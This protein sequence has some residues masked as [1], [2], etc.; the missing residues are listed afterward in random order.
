MRH[1]Y[2]ISFAIFVKCDINRLPDSNPIRYAQWM[3]YSAQIRLIVE[4]YM[5]EH[6]TD[7]CETHL[8][9]SW[10]IRCGLW[11]E[12]P[13]AVINRCAEAIARSLRTEILHDNV[14]AKHAVRIV[15]DG[16]QM[17]LW[18]DMRTAPREHMLLAFQ[19]RRQQIAADCRQL[20]IDVDYYNKNYNSETPIQLSFDFTA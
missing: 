17:T 18:A 10:A 3:T 13:S 2:Y 6:H 20:R 19:Q 11:E 5:A 7:V 8:V 9:A 12:H 4:R 15:R 16:M 1:P 14:R